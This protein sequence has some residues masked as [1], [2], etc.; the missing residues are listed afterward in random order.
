MKTLSKLI[1]VSFFLGAILI[2]MNACHDEDQASR[3]L[4]LSTYEE[5]VQIGD[6]ASVLVDV[7]D[8][9]GIS[10]VMIK[11]SISGQEV[12]D[13]QKEIS[14]SDT[15]FPYT[16]NEQII[17]G[18]EKGVVTYSFYGLNSSGDVVDASDLVLTIN[19]A[20]LPLLLR[21]DWQLTEQ[22]IQGEDYATDDLK[23]DVYR[24]N[25]DLS[26]E[27]DWGTIFSAAALE[28][29]N[30]TCSW[31][32]DMIGA[33]VDSLYMVK[34]NVFQPNTPVITRYKVVKLADREMVLESHQ[35]LSALGS[36]FSKNELVTEKWS[37]VT[38]SN[39]FT[40]Y[41]GSNPDNYFIEA[42][43]PGSYK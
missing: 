17:D 39:D 5:K 42:C 9:S 22:T 32:V 43:N 10:K 21:Y 4:T 15:Q 18:D 12:T 2:I 37:P 26:L 6:Y 35:D 8:N 27:W 11:K 7:T 23:D 3:A 41:R 19:I 24:F 36:D 30:S 14:L 38:K 31:D 25:E 40:P 16:F 20:Q 13:Y 29:L 1:I 34:Y 28:T 33:V